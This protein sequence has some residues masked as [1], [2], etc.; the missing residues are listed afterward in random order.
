[1]QV[2]GTTSKGED[3]HQIILSAGDLSVKI[4][5]WGA[6]LQDVRLAG[7]PYGL[8]LGS[9]NLSDYEGDMRHHGSLIGPVANRIS[10]ARARIDGM[11][12]ELERNQDG[13]IHLHSGAQ[14]TH[15]QVWSV[16]EVT[17]DSATLS[18]DLPDGM[19]GLPG[20]RKITVRYSVS[21]PTGLQMEV[22]GTTDAKT[23]MNFANHSYWNLDGTDSYAGHTLWIDAAHYLP[24]NEDD[25]PTGDILSVAGTEMDFRKPRTVGPKVPAF[26]NNYCLSNEDTALRDVLRLTGQSGVNMTVATTSP[27]IQVYDARNARRPGKAAYEGLAIEAQRWPDATN[28]SR[29]PSIKF[30]PDKPFAQT[31]SWTFST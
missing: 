24:A 16:E 18:L 25:Y 13:R 4:L 27:G 7:V 11:V 20:N 5:T 31:T 14:A 19:C 23:L 29:F 10:T 3:V 28:N 17:K 15:L 30:G 6:V 12:Y 2:F 21:A 1:M 26:D 9:D 22:T 8:T